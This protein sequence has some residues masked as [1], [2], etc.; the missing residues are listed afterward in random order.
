L[1]YPL[2]K[3][4]NYNC[5]PLSLWEAISSHPD[6]KRTFSSTGYSETCTSKNKHER[7]FMS[8]EFSYPISLKIKI[9]T[10]NNKT[11]NKT[12]NNELMPTMRDI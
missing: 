2:V 7:V 8:L 3:G 11:N 6:Q 10:E 4:D 5:L 9:Q 1:D 12:P